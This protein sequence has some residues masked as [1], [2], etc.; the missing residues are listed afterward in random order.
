LRTSFK[1]PEAALRLR[2]EILDNRVHQCTCRRQDLEQTVA[3]NEAVQDVAENNQRQR[4]ATCPN[5]NRGALP[6]HLPRYEVLIGVERRDC[7]CCGGELHPIGE[8]RVRV[9]R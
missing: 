8:L 7:S 1:G 6:A 5:R 4:R 3:A 9:S 2:N